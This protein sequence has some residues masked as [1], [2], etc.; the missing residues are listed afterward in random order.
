MTTTGAGS[1]TGGLSA[2][3]APLLTT[4]FNNIRN[5]TML[6]VTAGS[7]AT[8]GV[9]PYEWNKDSSDT[10]H[11]MT[12]TINGTGTEAGVPYIDVRVQGTY[13]GAGR[14]N[15]QLTFD[16]FAE[17][18]SIQRTQGV[19]LKLQAG[20]LSNVTVNTF[21]NL[22][23]TSGGYTNTIAINAR[24]PTGAA[25][26]T[27]LF[28][29]TYTTDVGTGY[30]DSNMQIAYADSVA[31][32]V[33][34]RIG[35]PQDERGT[36]VH[37]LQ[38]PG[39]AVMATN[40]FFSRSVPPTYYGMN[41][42]QPLSTNNPFPYPATIPFTSWRGTSFNPDINWDALNPSSGVFTW[43]NLETWIGLAQSGGLQPMYS[44]HGGNCPAFAGTC[45]NPTNADWQA[46]VTAIVTQANK[47]IRIWE[48]WNEADSVSFWTGTVAGMV[49]KAQWAYGAI[50]AIDP[51]AIVLCPS[52]TGSVAATGWL[53]DYLVA[54]GGAYCDAFNFHNYADTPTPLIPELKV[55]RAGAVQFVIATNYG[56]TKPLWDSESSYLNPANLPNDAARQQYIAKQFILSWSSGT[57]RSYWYSVDNPSKGTL[58]T[59]GGGYEAAQASYLE[60]S[61]WVRDA[62]MPSPCT[63]TGSVWT[64][65]ITRSGS[66][67]GFI[68]WDRAGSNYTVP[69]GITRYRTITGT[70][71]A[72]SQGNLVALS[73][74][75]LLFESGAPS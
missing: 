68:V 57:E 4:N 74:S 31:I 1:N 51:G 39:A 6:G 22:F 20:S 37:G 21:I 10:A 17:N 27:Q 18:G 30:V 54:G 16:S 33:T 71:T 13:D 2:G 61:G 47:R 50:K 75:P 46:F 36:S 23:D 19:Y 59:N 38:T 60:V 64:C 49:S 55:S 73:D 53:R 3:V 43:T 34:L 48:I 8:T 29:A 14:G 66:Y 58:W 44:L 69:A 11:G 24:T 56:Q 52:I 42:E 45:T 41:S 32:D 40:S 25:L 7:L 70:V 5:N 63:A 26:N 9:I 62:T 15:L 12:F 72:T 35:L 65:S 28:S 67:T